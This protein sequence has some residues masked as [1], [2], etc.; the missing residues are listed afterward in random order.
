MFSARRRPRFFPKALSGALVILVLAAGGYLVLE[1]RPV[2]FEAAQ[3]PGGP[4]EASSGQVSQEG[5]PDPGEAAALVAANDLEGR[6]WLYIRKGRFD[7]SSWDGAVMTALYP[8][9]VGE[10]PGDK[11]RVG[12]RRT[13]EGVFRVESIHD[14]RAWVH[15]FGDG[16]GPVE[17]AYGPFF[18]RLD[19]GRWKGIGIHGTHDPSSLGTM[20]TEGC[21]RMDNKA[22]LE[23]VDKAVPGTIV[24]IEP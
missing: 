6:F 18:I 4:G 16:K 24:I 13:P 19:T 8:V 3:E 10:N 7:L 9:A 21:I 23:I 20:T 12:D 22:L 5:F 1:R 17:G 15:D 11:E 2:A 14:S